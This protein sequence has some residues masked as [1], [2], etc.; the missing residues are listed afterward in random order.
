MR[1]T[2]IVVSPNSDVTMV[3]DPDVVICESPIRDHSTNCSSSSS[4]LVARTLHLIRR[5]HWNP[6]IFAS[7]T[8]ILLSAPLADL[9]LASAGRIF[10][11]QTR[12]C[13]A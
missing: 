2:L 9:Y 13:P 7:D 12:Q 10:F 3:T 8:G 5:P 1:A 6:A 11:L 4:F